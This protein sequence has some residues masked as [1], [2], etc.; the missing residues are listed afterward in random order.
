VS[1][2]L[3]RLTALLS[4]AAVVNGAV[5]CSSDTSKASSSAT[6]QPPTESSSVGSRTGQ[7]STSPAGTPSTALRVLSQM[8]LAARVGQLFMVGTSS[9]KTDGDT[10]DAIAKYH[11]GGVILNGNSTASIEDTIVVTT[12][13]Q[14]ASV[15]QSKPGS[16]RLLLSTDQEGGQVQRLRGTGFERMPTGLE[17]GK[18]SADALR[19]AAKRWGEALTSAGVNMNLCPV[20]DTVPSAEFASNNPPIGAFDREFGYTPAA[21]SSHGV[22]VID[23]YTQ[24]GVATS[25]KHFPGLG[26]VTGN[27]DTTAGVT[28]T[29]TT[30]TDPYLGPFQAAIADHVPAV[31]MSTAIYTRLDPAQPAAFSQRIVTDLLRKT[32]HF[33]GV[34]LSDDLGAAEQVSDVPV[35]D[36]ATRFIAAGGD[37][38]LTVDPT[39]VAPMAAAVLAQAQHDPTFKTQIDAAVLRILTL[40]QRFNL[41]PSG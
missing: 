34:V 12:A 24:A 15:A 1:G 7:A 17:Q 10:L 20:L 41:I 31:M 14:N 23:G 13:L 11:V 4:I 9:T 37:I 28:D 27:T 32:M 25:A 26:K 29:T 5:A 39:N 19:A 35:A 18:M 3:G 38:V 2:P 30:A 8:D 36:R 33:D 22:A 21:V 16:P 40:K 6:T